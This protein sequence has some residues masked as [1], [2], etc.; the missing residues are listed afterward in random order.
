MAESLLDLAQ[1]SVTT[2]LVLILCAGVIGA[3]PA[4]A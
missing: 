3:I 4:L 1:L 2:W